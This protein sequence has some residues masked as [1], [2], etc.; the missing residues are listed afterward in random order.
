MNVKNKEKVI[1][2]MKAPVASKQFGQERILCPIIADVRKLFTCI[3][4]VFWV[5]YQ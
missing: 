4:P 1:L 5:S 3:F 2:R